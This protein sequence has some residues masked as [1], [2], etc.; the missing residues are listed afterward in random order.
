MS[1]N[2][3]VVAFFC[4]TYLKP[5]M[6]H[7][8]R[9]ILALDGWQPLVLAQKVENPGTFPMD[10]LEVVPRSPWRFAARAVER[11]FTLAPWQIS[12]GETARLRAVLSER[13]AR[14][15]H[16]FFGNVAVHLLPLIESVE[17]PVVVSFHGAD[18]AGDIATP[19]YRAARKRIFAQ[20]ARVACRSEALVEAVHR[21]GCPR[22]KLTVIRTALPELE[23]RERALPADGSIQLVQAC[24]LVPKKGLVTTL[25]AFAKLSPRHPKM[26]LVIAGTGPLDT[27]LR[28]RAAQ[29]GVASRVRFAGFLDQSALRELF[30]SSHVFLHPSETVAGDV[31]GIPNGL[32]EAMATGLPVVATRHGGIP[33][34][35]EHEVGGLLCEERDAGGVAEAVERLI[36]DPGL[37][38]RIAAGGAAAVRSK[39]S[40]AAVAEALDR[41]YRQ[42]SAG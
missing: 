37:Y 40:R 7:L 27:K 19:G 17:I 32:L 15:L 22:E 24:R 41:L 20:A 23:F 9:Q 16:V 21:L 18:V 42:V 1:G 34:A 2:E 12:R 39:F 26:T 3:P 36:G 6:H 11:H 33:E 25:A 10:G 35:V 14:V 4:A 38:A 5:E 13:R 28:E 31:E 30:A 8:H 29:L